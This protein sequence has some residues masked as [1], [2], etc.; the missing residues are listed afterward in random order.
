MLLFSSV[1]AAIVTVAAVARI[2]STVDW[3]KSIVI[4]VWF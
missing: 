3:M 4:V 2:A 1:G